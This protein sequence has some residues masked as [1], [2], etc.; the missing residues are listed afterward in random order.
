M[1]LI[2]KFVSSNNESTLPENIR[3]NMHGEKPDPR[4]ANDLPVHWREID[5]ATF[6]KSKFFTYSPD[7]WEFRQAAIDGP[8]GYMASIRIF[9]FFDGTCYGIVGEHYN[10]KVRYF[11][12]GCEHKYIEFRSSVDLAKAYPQ[13]SG[14]GNFGMHDHTYVCEKC[15][16]FMVTDSSG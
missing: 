14:K 5:V 9:W 13:Y 1:S 16:H 4:W 12:G 10:E 11:A 2:Y 6:A 7:Y 3:K 15:Q 8:S